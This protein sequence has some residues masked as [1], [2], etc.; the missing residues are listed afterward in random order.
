MGVGQSQSSLWLYV[1]DT[2]AA[3]KRAVDA[4]AKVVMPVGDQFW[5]D[6]MGQ[7]TDPFG[8]R[9]SM[10]TR[11]KDMTQEEQRAAADAFVAQMAKTKP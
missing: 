7:V 9:W 1:P 2:D 3:F 5:G 8:Q 11:I 10:A 6:R 4:G